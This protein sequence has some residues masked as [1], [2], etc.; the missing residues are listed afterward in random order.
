MSSPTVIPELEA[1]PVL[2]L[3]ANGEARTLE[4]AEEL[5]LDR[6]V[7]EIVRLIGSGLS[8]E[9]LLNH[10]LMHLL[11]AHGSRGWEDSLA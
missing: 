3:I 11:R 7:P 9:D 6:S 2:R 1:D 8:D 4:E 5:Y 10:P